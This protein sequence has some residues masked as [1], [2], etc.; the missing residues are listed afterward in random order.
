M[1]KT[2]GLFMLILSIVVVV[3]TLYIANKIYVVKN[4]VAVKTPSPTPL[5]AFDFNNLKKTKFPKTQ[6]I[7]GR[8]INQNNEYISRVFYYS[9]PKTPGSTV[10]EKVSGLAN[11]PQKPGTYPVIIMYRGFVPDNIYKPGVGTQPVASVLAQNG[12]ITLAPDFLGYGESDMPSKDPFENRFQ[13]YTTAVTLLS[14]IPTLNKGLDASYS[15]QIKADMGKIGIWGHSN[16]GH[17]ALSTLE[18]TGVK[19][20]TVLWAPVSTSFPYSILYYTDESQDQGMALR[21]TLAG[22]EAT[23]NTNLFSPTNYLNWIKAPIL[24]NQGTADEEVPY[25]WSQNLVSQLQKDGD[26]A[27]LIEYDGADHNMLPED[28]WSRAVGNTLNFY[29]KAFN[30]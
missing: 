26:S 17:I 27:N 3:E 23:Y 1:K 8:V 2:V 15:G 7:F 16:G 18:I 6:I 22:F 10:L 19:Y 4:I 20:P 24:V 28:E 30:K 29:N 9:V 5:I 25:W 11:I 21:K 13:T 12:Y 14:S